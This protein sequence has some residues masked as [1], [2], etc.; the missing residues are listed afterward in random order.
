MKQNEV[1]YAGVKNE[2]IL[3]ELDVLIETE[4]HR[5]VEKNG[6]HHSRHEA[7]AVLEEELFEAEQELERM[8]YVFVLLKELVFCDGG[9]LKIRKMLREIEQAATNGML[10]M[11]QAGAMTK[12]FDLY[13]QTEEP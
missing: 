6:P 8:K 3:R 10:E 9:A 12:K 1:K 13:M 11:M 4:C 7:M 2:K 5:G